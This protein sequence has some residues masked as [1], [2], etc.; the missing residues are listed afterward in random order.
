MVTSLVLLSKR[1]ISKKIKTK[2]RNFAKKQQPKKREKERG[3]IETILA[4]R[5]KKKGGLGIKNLLVQNDALLMKQ[6]HKFYQKED[7]PLVQQLW[8]RYYGK[9][10]HAQRSM[11]SF[12]W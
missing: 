11:G 12:W 7:V 8:F 10:P 6:L 9:V 2:S 1:K 3:N 5:P 4:Q